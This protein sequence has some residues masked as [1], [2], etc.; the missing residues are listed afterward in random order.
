MIFDDAFL[1]L[2]CEDSSEW[3]RLALMHLKNEAFNLAQICLEK[4][5]Q[6]KNE[7]LYHLHLANIL[8]KQLR[9]AEA[10]EILHYMVATF[11]QYAEAFHN[12]ANLYFK[13]ENWQAAIKNYQLAI[14]IQPT[15]SDAYYHLGLVYKKIN[16]L[17][18]AKETFKTLLVL[19][20]D[21]FHA[22]FQL[23]L[24]DMQLCAWQKAIVQFE[25]YLKN[26][27]KHLEAQINLAHCYYQVGQIS[28][29][30]SLYI[31]IILSYPDEVEVLYNL[32]VIAEEEAELFFALDFYHKVIMCDQKHISAHHNLA[33]LYLKLNHREIALFYFQKVLDLDPE[34]ISVKYLSQALQENQAIAQAPD[35][36][37][38]EL[39]N[40]Y[41]SHY[42]EHLKISLQY[43]VP[44]QLFHMIKEANL[45]LPTKL[46]ILD[47][48]CGTGLCGAYFKTIAAILHGVDLSKA[49]LEVAKE[50]A[51][52]DKLICASLETYLMQPL[53]QY[54]LILAGDVFVYIGDL[55]SIFSLLAKNLKQG[56]YVAF[57]VE[58]TMQQD[59]LLQN[60]GRF[61]H[62]QNYINQLAK[63]FHFNILQKKEIV[64]RSEY[65]KS[66]YGYIYLLQIFA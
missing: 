53:K 10:K 52:Y 5:I 6:L 23:A 44:Q 55:A 61:A 43:E 59:K 26:Y 38:S 4:A 7:P 36:Y 29:A 21:Y 17:A 18:E 48:G 14:N 42:D 58:K 1:A 9:F 27:P 45:P 15:Y 39:F 24:I 47:L 41:A 33:A 40:A 19:R 22:H 11:P 8:K 57:S 25:T 50:K 60:N 65:N 66:V 37:L 12:L 35:V 46:A 13:E 34:N 54:D 63:Q 20:P 56:A 64:I 3:H 49:M 30:K 31:S 28:H 62:H 51:I 2:E 16:Y 32:A